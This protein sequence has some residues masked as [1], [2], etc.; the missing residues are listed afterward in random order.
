MAISGDERLKSILDLKTVEIVEL[1]KD[2]SMHSYRISAYFKA[3]GYCIISINPFAEVV[4]GKK[5]TRIFWTFPMDLRASS[6]STFSGF[7]RIPCQL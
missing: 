4:F 6:L 2:Y 7:L 3:N 1:S 5:A